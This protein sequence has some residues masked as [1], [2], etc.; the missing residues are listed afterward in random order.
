MRR[1]TGSRYIRQEIFEPIGP[2]GQRRIEASAAVIVGCGAL[3]S[4]IANNLARSG[5]GRLRIVDRDFVELDNLQRQVL[6]DEDDVRRRMPKAVAAVRR[7]AEINSDIQLDAEVCEISSANI[8]ALIAGFD[9][10]M[11]G[12]D[13][14]ETRLLLNDACLKARVPYVFGG[15]VGSTGMTMAVVAD[16]TPCYRCLMTELP[17]P[18]TAPTAATSG[19]LHSIAATIASLQCTSAL[20]LLTGTF[21]AAGVLLCVDAW[22]QELTRMDVPRLPDCPACGR[23]EFEFLAAAPRPQ[24]AAVRGTNSVRLPAREGR[25]VSPA[26]LAEEWSGLGDVVANEWLVSLTVG[27]HEIIAFAD[28]RGLVKGTDDVGEAEALFARR[29]EGTGRDRVGS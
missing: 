3:G 1:S 10:V 18:G 2:E 19:V 11:D 21:D 25:A 4:N 13:N 29:V 7:L 14:V 5:V 16:Q 28:G 12:T 6:F 8:E 20:R 9:V 17:A 22:E 23:R 15:V 27:D 26:R 24:A